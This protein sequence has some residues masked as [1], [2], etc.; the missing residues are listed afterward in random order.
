MKYLI[1]RKG[2]KDVTV[3]TY[4]PFGENRMFTLGLENINCKET[5]QATRSQLPI[6]IKNH[7]F[8]Y[9]VDMKGEFRNTTL[10]DHTVGLRRAW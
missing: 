3:V 2:G 6:K 8:H 4:T 9:I 7:W 1:L 5:R 10:F